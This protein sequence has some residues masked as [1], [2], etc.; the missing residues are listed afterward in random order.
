MSVKGLRELSLACESI[1]AVAPGLAM[2]TGHPG[3]ELQVQPQPPVSARFQSFAVGDRSIAIMEGIGAD[4]AIRRFLDRRGPG[5]FSM[6]FEVEDVER[7][8]AHLRTCG[9]RLVLDQPMQLDG[10]TGSEVFE[11]IRINFVAPGGPAH[12]LVFELQELQGGRSAL[13]PE[14]RSGPDVP[15]AINE[16]HCAVRDVDAAAADLSRLFGFEV[17][18]EVVQAEPPEQVRYRNL[19]LGERSAIALIGPSC[20]ESTVH[21]FLE[22]RGAGIFSISMRVPDGAAYVARLRTAGL[23]PLFEEPKAVTGGRIGRDY[24]PN[25]SIWWIRPSSATAKVLFEIQ[26]YT[27]PPA[28]RT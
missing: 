8:S 16:I 19:Y 7:A 10:R 18:P 26:E 6:T 27:S 4:N 3:Y 24:L 23:Q 25:V 22:R 17:G 14:A 5:A 1:P 15:V 28:V 2:V 21:R 13:H 11:S 9:A 20:P 12:G